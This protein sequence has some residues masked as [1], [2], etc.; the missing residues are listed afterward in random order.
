MDAGCLHNFFTTPPSRLRWSQTE[1]KEQK[2]KKY[3]RYMTKRLQ[4]GLCK[5][6][7]EMFLSARTW[8]SACMNFTSS[9]LF[10]SSKSFIASVMGLGWLYFVYG[11]VRNKFWQTVIFD[12]HHSFIKDCICVIKGS[13][14]FI[15]QKVF[16]VVSFWAIPVQRTRMLLRRGLA[17]QSFKHKYPYS[18]KWERQRRMTEQSFWAEKRG[19]DHEYQSLPLEKHL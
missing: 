18:F 16:K 12:N 13:Y 2:Y 14:W 9:P 1:Q 4:N 17:Q 19:L 5:S 3:M 15:C 11:W 7:S 8:A 10:S 6:M